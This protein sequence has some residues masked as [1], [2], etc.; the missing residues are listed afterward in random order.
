MTLIAQSAGTM[1]PYQYDRILAFFESSVELGVKLSSDSLFIREFDDIPGEISEIAG[2]VFRR[3]KIPE[4]FFILGS[5][6][7]IPFIT[8][9]RSHNL[10]PGICMLRQ[11]FDLI[12]QEIQ[13][14]LRLCLTPAGQSFH[15][16]IKTELLEF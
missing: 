3:R 9:E 8:A 10:N 4:A 12:Y 13:R 6:L 1:H 14:W 15:S 11:R 7:V 2:T 16:E 5:N